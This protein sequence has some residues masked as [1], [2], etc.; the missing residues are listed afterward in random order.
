MALTPLV[1]AH[2]NVTASRRPRQ[3][4]DEFELSI[5]PSEPHVTP[6]SFPAAHPSRATPSTSSSAT[7]IASTNTTLADSVVSYPTSNSYTSAIST[8]S[9]VAK[10][11]SK[12]RS[13]DMDWETID[14][15]VRNVALPRTPV[16]RPMV[17]PMLGLT[18]TIPEL[19]LDRMASTTMSLPKRPVLRPSSDEDAL[20]EIPYLDLNV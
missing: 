2:F 9:V 14:L 18:T 17:L 19:S 1:R 3:L 15:Q 10:P 4:P 13:M 11:I 7:S 6:M 16:L 8:P 5:L 12:V 20:N